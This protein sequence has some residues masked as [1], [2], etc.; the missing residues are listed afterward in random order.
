M[1]V[2]ITQSMLYSRA[3]QDIRRSSLG[4]IRLQEQVSTGRLVNR[5]SDDPARALRILPL[6]RELR[7]LAGLAEHQE[8]RAELRRG[9]LDW[10]SKTGGGSLLRQGAHSVPV[11]AANQVLSVCP[12]VQRLDSDHPLRGYSI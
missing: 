7:N 5:P 9:V 1:S 10:W 3:L 6:N 12:A 8:L 4:L 11:S 2:R